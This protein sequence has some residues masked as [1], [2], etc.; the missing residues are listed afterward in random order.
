MTK[1]DEF[2]EAFINDHFHNHRD[3]EEHFYEKVF[4]LKEFNYEGSAYRGNISGINNF[5]QNINQQKYK[6][7]S[8]SLDGIKNFVVNESIDGAFINSLEETFFIKKAQIIGID[9]SKIC[10]H[11]KEKGSDLDI[12]DHLIS[13]NEVILIEFISYEKEEFGLLESRIVSFLSGDTL[14][15]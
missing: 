6:S 10:L 7:W 12:I 8:K 9:V 5:D 15:I 4:K 13:E 1:Q 3:V 14:E 2:L 11:L